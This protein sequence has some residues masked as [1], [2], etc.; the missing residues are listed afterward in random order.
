M[1]TAAALWRDA[2]ALPNGW[3]LSC[4]AECDGSQTKVYNTERTRALD[5]LGTGAGSFKRVLDSTITDSAEAG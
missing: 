4:G 5:L 1:M 2:M 3:R